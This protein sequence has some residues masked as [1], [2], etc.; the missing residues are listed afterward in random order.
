MVGLNIDVDGLGKKL[1]SIAAKPQIAIVTAKFG[2]SPD[3]LATENSLYEHLL[4]LLKSGVALEIALRRLASP[5]WLRYSLELRRSGRSQSEIAWALTD[6]GRLNRRG[7]SPLF[8]GVIPWVLSLFRRY[9]TPP[10][11]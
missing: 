1:L 9:R 10:I 11:Q 8:G 7:S 5:Q 3:A 4:F 2:M 6:E